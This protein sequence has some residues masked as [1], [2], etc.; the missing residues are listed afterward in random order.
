[1]ISPDGRSPMARGME[2]VTRIMTISLE[3]VLPGLAGY[4]LDQRLHTVA[5]FMLIG[6]ALGCTAAVLHLIKLTRSADSK[7]EPE[8]TVGR[9]KRE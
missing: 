3:M 5:L 9:D 4:W 7:Q 1:M 8:Q 6:F 2:W